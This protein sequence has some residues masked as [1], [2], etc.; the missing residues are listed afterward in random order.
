[1]FEECAFAET[2]FIPVCL[3]AVNAG[4]FSQWAALHI[5]HRM[6]DNSEYDNNYELSGNYNVTGDTKRGRKLA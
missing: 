3:Y 5:F 6:Q 1:L 2:F 4:I